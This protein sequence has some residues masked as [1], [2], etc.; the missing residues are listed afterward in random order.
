[1]LFAQ[2][3]SIRPITVHRKLALVIGN[4]AY[5]RSPLLNPLRDAESITSMLRDLGFE[6]TT[7]SNLGLREFSR[8]ADEFSARLQ[9]GDLALFYYSGHGM[10]VNGENYI[11]PVDFDG[12]SE[13]DVPYTAYAANRIRDKLE[14][15]GAGLRIMILDACRDNPFKSSKGGPSGLAPMAST[16]EG[17]FIAFATG[18]NNTASDNPEG[19]N[20]LFTQ[21]L[22][23]ALK[24][25]GLEL[26]DVFQHVKEGV[27][28]ASKKRQNPFTYDDVAG[29]Y[30]LRPDDAKPNGIRPS[31]HTIAAPIDP[32]EE[33]WTGI[34][35]SS[36]PEDFDDFM[37]AFPSSD[38]T[39]AAR[40]RAAQLRNAPPMAATNGSAEVSRVDDLTTKGFSAYNRADYGNAMTLCQ[41]AAEKGERQCMRLLGYMYARG[42]GSSQDF[43]EAVSWWRKAAALGDTSAMNGMGGAY[44]DGKGVRLD[45]AEAMQWYLKSAA[46]GDPYGLGL[47]GTMY[48][49]GTGVKQDYAE[50]MRWFRKAADAN[51]PEAC[52]LIARIYESGL[53]VDKNRTEAILW[54]HKSAERGYAPAKDRLEA[55]EK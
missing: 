36:K 30:Y 32:A 41:K 12:S 42:Q 55:L 45:Y 16:A 13:A 19:K 50:A 44:L 15:S 31:E 24:E 28:Y 25:P 21:Y 22:L 39:T 48:F 54:Y 49:D 18:D 4:A 51:N 29:S 11:L 33:A 17:T 38:L 26:R 43:A 20:G 46:L 34:K 8:T 52:Y 9:A 10:Q 14:R 47:V 40:M 53:G 6:V 23:A 35:N 3:R 37:R 1:M 2:S 7:G 5:P 27:Y